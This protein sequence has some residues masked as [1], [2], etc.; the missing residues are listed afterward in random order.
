MVRLF[1]L[2]FLAPALLSAQIPRIGALEFYG[3]RRVP[4]ERIRKVLKVEESDRLPPSKEDV[5]ERLETI[6][7]VIRARLEAVCCAG[8]AAS[9][10][11]GIEEKGAVHFAVRSEPSGSAVLPDAIMQQ[12]RDFL[13][14]LQSAVA[15]GRT[16][17]DLTQGHSLMADAECRSYQEEFLRIAAREQPLLRQVLR[18]SSDSDH[19]AAAAYI[20]AYAEKKKAVLNDLQ[21]ALQDPD[22][23]VRSNAIRALEAIAILAERKP[24]LEIEVST[25]WFI[26]M[27]NSLVLSDRHRASVALAHLTEK[28]RPSDVEQIRKRALP[29]VVE[30]ARWKTL[31]YALPAFILAGRIAGLPE[32]EIHKAWNERQ[33]EA[34]IEQALKAGRDK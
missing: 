29:A 31:E 18:E 30:M 7:G 10:F 28:A 12:Y 16:A 24:D 22:P 26:E 14:A 19:R 17:E 25:T 21:F 1:L 34:V 33:R 6:P 32:A 5:E 2:T 11:V 23:P 3:I 4:E 20:L 15:R 9:L 8:G 27:L 13:G